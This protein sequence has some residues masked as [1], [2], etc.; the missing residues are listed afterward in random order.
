MLTSDS[1]S[2]DGDNGGPLYTESKKYAEEIAFE[3]ALA[4]THWAHSAGLKARVPKRRH[5]RI[6]ESE[7]GS[8][9]S[10]NSGAITNELLAHRRRGVSA[11]RSTTT[12]AASVSRNRSRSVATYPTYS[13]NQPQNVDK[14]SASEKFVGAVLRKVFGVDD[15]EVLQSLFKDEGPLM[16]DED[17]RR[18]SRSATAMTRPSLGVRSQ[19]EVW[20]RTMRQQRMRL[21][22][23]RRSL[24]EEE[25]DVIEDSDD[26][27]EYPTLMKKELTSVHPYELNNPHP[28][29]E[30]LSQPS[31]YPQR[32]RI[33]GNVAEPSLTEALQAT[34]ISG[35]RLLP[36]SLSIFLAGS[37]SV[38]FMHYLI[39]RFGPMF[40]ERIRK[41]V[42][43]GADEA[44]IESVLGTSQAE[45]SPNGSSAADS[46]FRFKGSAHPVLVTKS[47]ASSAT[48]LEG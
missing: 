4:N 30:I 34:M 31:A 14:R 46:E 19:D 5:R 18:A 48:V 39:D 36:G 17:S 2:E 37:H 24:Q 27:V 26:E 15:D 10:N 11:R 16:I 42:D 8:K 33:S 3:E 13:S 21:L 29:T 7:K 35:I 25:E 1:E 12:T 20:S 32:A 43:D 6:G 40:T 44:T 22:V 47:P 41:L 45:L 23:E 38:R 28:I 9:R